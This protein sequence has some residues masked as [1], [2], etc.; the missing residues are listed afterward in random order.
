MTKIYRY[1]ILLIIVGLQINIEAAE[2]GL[3]A[4]VKIEIKQEL[5]LERQAFDAHM[6]ISNGLTN[7]DLENLK[8]NVTFADENGDPV[9]ATSDPNDTTALFFI[10]IDTMEGIDDINGNGVIPASSS[11]DIHWLI[12]PAPGSGGTV[13][14]L[15]YIGA[16]LEYA[17]GGEEHA[18]EVTA[19]YIF[20]KPQPLLTLDYFLP[21]EVYGDDAFT[22]E[23]EPPVPYTLG[24]RI[25]ND[26]YGVAR[27]LKIESA[28]PRIVENELGLLIGFEIIGSSVNNQP[29]NPSLLIDFGDI[30]A[31]K[32]AVGRWQM[33][34]TL[35]G[36]FTEFNASFTHADELGGELTSLI[37]ATNTHFLEKDVLVDLPGR[38]DIRDF[39]AKDGDIL[40]VYESHGLDTEVNDHSGDATLQL[41][42]QSTYSIS[43]PATA[44]FLY[45]KLSDP[46]AGTKAIKQ[47]VRSDGKVLS[48]DNVWLS[49][50]RRE[51]NEWDYFIKLFDSNSTG[52]Y[53]ITLETVTQGAQAPVLQFIP[54]RTTPENQQISFLVKA[55]DPNGTIPALSA[56]N[57]PSGAR[58]VVQNEG[59][60]FFDWTPVK[61]QA[62]SYDVTFTASDGTLETSQTA[63]IIVYS[64]VE[65]SDGDGMPDSC[66][67]Q[68]FGNLERDGRSD[69][70]N[71]GISDLEECL[72]GSDPSLKIPDIVI[73]E[74][75]SQVI[76]NNEFIELYDGG[77]G[78]TPLDGLMVVLFDGESDQSYAAFDL[79]GLTT[80]ADGYFVIGGSEIANADLT[81]PEN[82]WLADGTDAIALYMGNG[83]PDGT[84]ITTNNLL[85]ALVY[86]TEDDL[87]LLA[88]LNPDE[89][90]ID[91]DGVS[92]SIGR[93]ENGAGGQR[94]TSHYVQ[95]VPTPS[96]VNS[97]EADLSVVMVDS[98]D[99]V[100]VGADLSYTL[101][102]NNAGSDVASNVQVEN[103]LAAGVSFISASGTCE[104][105]D[106][107]VT[108][109]L[110]QL[111]IG[112]SESI[113]INVTA[114]STV[115]EITNEATVSATTLDP[116]IS[117]NTV[118]EITTV[119][120]LPPQADLSLTLAD[121]T[122][123]VY[124]G[125]NLSYTLTVN[126]AGSDI[127]NNVQVENVLAAGVSFISASGTCQ[128]LDGIVTCDLAQLAVGDSEPITINVTAPSTLGE[129]INTATVSAS[130]LDPNT[131]N[132]TVSEVTTII[133]LP[134]ADLSLTLVD[135]ADPVYVG[136]NFSYTLTVNNAGS[137]IANNVQVENILATGVSFIGATGTDWTCQ[138]LN[139]TVTCDLAQLAVGDSESITINVTAPS[140]LGEITNTATVSATTIDP[141][142][143]NNSVSE[144]T[145]IQSLLTIGEMGTYSV[146]H[147]WQTIGLSETYSSTPIV[148]AAPAS[149]NDL[150]PGVVRLRNVGTTDF[151]LR[152]Q[153]W[154]YLD[155]QHAQET[156]PYLALETGRY[157]MED[158]NI[159]E[160][161]QFQLDG[162]GRW[163][164]IQFSQN[165]P[166]QPRLFLTI[167]TYNDS[168]PVTVRA[169]EVTN[170]HFKAALFE[171][172]QTGGNHAEE[173]IGYLAIYSTSSAG[174]V[175][176]GGQN[177]D[178]QL[179]QIALDTTSPQLGLKLEEE[180]SKDDEIQHAAETVEVLTF[181]DISFGQIST[182]NENDTVTLRQAFSTPPANLGEQGVVE[183]SHQWKNTDFTVSYQ[184]PV[185]IAAPASNNDFELGV[186]R[187]RNV[188]TSNF[189][190][191]FQ[192]WQYLDSQHAQ[193]TMPYLA[194]EA[195]RY[196]MP[197]GNI[198]EVGQFGLD[199]SKKWK[200][201]YFNQV[202]PAQPR[203]FLTIQTYNDSQPVTV[204]AQEVTNSYFKAALFEEEKK[205]GNHA[206][207]TI[208]YLAIYSASGA[209]IVTLGGQSLDYQ[210]QQITLDTTLPQLGLK[211]EE[212]Q[213][214][215]DEIQHVAETVDVLTL[216]GIRF[217]QIS[218]INEKDTVVLRNS[219]SPTSRKSAS[220]V[221]EN[222]GL[223][224]N[225]SNIQTESAAYFIGILGKLSNNVKIDFTIYPA[226]EDINQ[227]AEILVWVKHHSEEVMAYYREGLDW[228]PW[229][230]EKES[231]QA[232]ASYESL[233]D[234]LE[235]NV[236]QGKLE[237][238]GEFSLYV[239]YRLEDGR[240]VYNGLEPVVFFVK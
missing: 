15:Y 108:C 158:G 26:G 187:L 33:I 215:D 97:C 208:G 87:G 186:V 11:A 91:E 166:A 194:L 122:D 55:S 100:Y 84:A 66:E 104:E 124:V 96:V 78:N 235:V 46:L 12:I 73:N 144:T 22:P 230:G 80:D 31:S 195:G 204:R 211:L 101:T 25:K 116:N 137:D 129:I 42:S 111:A 227:P 197:D 140:T 43:A 163:E 68:Y 69:F 126:N 93:C 103:V 130:T 153:E 191:Q 14:T 94:N 146:N 105:L 39:L 198:W 85:D 161:G 59:E 21:D 17:M 225:Q 106:G 67:M 139:G 119:I 113:T 95:M 16:T 222:N 205:G 175:T 56:T 53:Q 148:I 47:V 37:E 23:I 224:I 239:A 209:G 150:E 86:G 24:V 118:S 236:Y 159:W 221:F 133:P 238:A 114:P 206:E 213:S 134:Q 40:R 128:E 90:Q 50:S 199:K 98:A 63:R 168:Q 123:P 35:S 117:N 32:T 234:Y 176:L 165:F 182:I 180:Q 174:I 82:D 151:E 61:G 20:V 7:L 79:D 48:L 220:L 185:I 217:G 34:T 155:D 45:V 142:T 223:E 83:F 58:F 121:S 64:S 77:I 210:L 156:I 152:F 76:E 5:T 203:L 49:K 172:E 38:D 207:E 190:L 201:V 226:P 72:L 57:L 75:D 212:E 19:D 30:K 170:S 127:A 3:C 177:L 36:E 81:V 192:E 154:Q 135:S 160:V 189:E 178:Y 29:A 240:L 8:I 188:E 44:G 99:P 143:D 233:P 89:P 6:R 115:G 162:S 74:A 41:E 219:T 193:E 51:N 196:F 228:H 54:D 10:D 2:E 107:I 229:D 181:G 237:F 171:E 70:D 200:T 109:D 232:A 18:T 183:T 164:T 131:D 60:A 125:A 145:T 216:G 1:L 92:D 173:T 218:T 102:V 184:N 179:Q 202:F 157:L 231:L 136:A 27:Q 214:K 28:Q 88:L 65:D 13:G 169:Q 71:D 110:A 138:E 149:S 120:P 147:N 62:G 52:Q 112:D 141:N 167:Q 4:V 9:H 132:N